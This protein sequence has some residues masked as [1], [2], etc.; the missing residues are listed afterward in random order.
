M[1]RQ[2]AAGVLHPHQAWTEKQKVIVNALDEF[3]AS[4]TA[5]EKDNV[6]TDDAQRTYT[7]P[8]GRLG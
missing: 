6:S 3:A 8:H 7:R 2:G 4:L 5:T 1:G